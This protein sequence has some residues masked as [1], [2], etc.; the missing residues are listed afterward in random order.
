MLPSAVSQFRQRLSNNGSITLRSFD[1]KARWKRPQGLLGDN[2]D[3]TFFSTSAYMIEYG[4]K[5]VR[6][7]AAA[8][9]KALPSEDEDTGFYP[10]VVA[11]YKGP[12]RI[13]SNGMIEIQFQD[14]ERTWPTMQLKP[15][16]GSLLLFP[17]NIDPKGRTFVSRDSDFWPFRELMGNEEKEALR[18][19]KDRTRYLQDSLN[20]EKHV[21]RKI[22]Q[23]V[24]DLIV[25]PGHSTAIVLFETALNL[26]ANGRGQ[27]VVH[28]VFVGMNVIIIHDKSVLKS[29]DKM[30][31][32]KNMIVSVVKPYK[33]DEADIIFRPK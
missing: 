7:K 23:D 5:P 10:R 3:I 4:H 21:E 17:E 19:I 12:Y 22:Q 20:Y 28:P 8:T 33:I 29:E 18:I 1:G 32:V 11:G 9:S 26:K 27:Y 16:P 14:P 31:Q 25:G 6:S 24:L 30:K 13:Q 15:G 2:V